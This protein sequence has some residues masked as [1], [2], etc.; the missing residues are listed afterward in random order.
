MTLIKV[1]QLLSQPLL[2]QE[3]KMPELNNLLKHHFS[4]FRQLMNYLGL[5]SGPNDKAVWLAALASHLSY[6]D[7][8]NMVFLYCFGERIFDK[9]TNVE[10]PTLPG[11][12]EK[13]LEILSCLLEPVV[14]HKTV[15]DRYKV[16]CSRLLLLF[17]Q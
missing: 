10:D 3:G 6:M 14:V 16:F 12:Q 15:V 8:A 1:E 2:S 5:V 7:P 4:V 17:C 11:V 13:L 9:F